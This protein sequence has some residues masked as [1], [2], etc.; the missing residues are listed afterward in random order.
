MIAVTYL[1]ILIHRHVAIIKP[2]MSSYS[3]IVTVI[4]GELLVISILQSVPGLGLGEK[5]SFFRQFPSFALTFSRPG[6]IKE[7]N[8]RDRSGL[9]G[10]MMQVMHGGLQRDKNG[11]GRDAARSQKSPAHGF[12]VG[13]AEKYQPIAP[14]TSNHC[15]EVGINEYS[16][17]KRLIKLTPDTAYPRHEHL[18]MLIPHEF[19]AAE[20]SQIEVSHVQRLGEASPPVLSC[21]CHAFSMHDLVWWGET[22]YVRLLK[23]DSD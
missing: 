5:G 21:R 18:S 20:T 13:Y 6:Q 7:Y 17:L 16:G 1:G 15:D 23:L 9:A 22:F 10:T 19:E 3:S 4:R 11:L 8:Q 2:P 14:K 12:S